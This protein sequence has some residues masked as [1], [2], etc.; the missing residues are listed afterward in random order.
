M[1]LASLQYVPHIDLILRALR[2]NRERLDSK[3]KVAIDAR[4]LKALL[5]TIAQCAPFSEDFYRETCPDIARAHAAGRIPDL[6][7]HYVE[8]GF[9]E[10]RL[11]APPPVD[12]GYYA[13]L[14]PD[15]TQAMLC[16]EVKSGAEHYR[17]SVCAEGRI[18][19]ASLKPVV[20]AWMQLRRD[21]AGHG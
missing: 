5:K 19:N 18:P 2:I 4:L 12:E 17:N 16:G 21:A 8:F 10:G 20:D 15:V 14:Y 1:Q 9:F 6:R 13:S 3:S 11:G 7:R